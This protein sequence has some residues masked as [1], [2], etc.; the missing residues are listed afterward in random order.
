MTAPAAIR[1]SDMDRAAA[2]AKKH[3]CVVEI[4]K[5]GMKFRFMPDNPDIHSAPAVDPSPS[6]ASN[7]LAAW[8]ARHEGRPRGNPSR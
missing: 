4:E 8:R 5:D 1:K 7:G 6:P 3:G 2:M